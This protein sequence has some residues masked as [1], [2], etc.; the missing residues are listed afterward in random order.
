M[1]SDNTTEFEQLLRTAA[2]VQTSRPPLAGE[3]KTELT[4]KATRDQIERRAY[5]IYV[6]RGGVHGRDLEDWLQAEREVTTMR[7]VRA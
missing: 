4:H 2:R 6:S 1:S 3:P 7:A 5:E